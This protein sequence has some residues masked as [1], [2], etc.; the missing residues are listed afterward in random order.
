[1]INN[2]KYCYIVKMRQNLSSFIVDFRQNSTCLTSYYSIILLFL[3]GYLVIF[4]NFVQAQS[5]A[6]PPARPAA[7][8]NG[9]PSSAQTNQNAQSFQNTTPSSR[10][11]KKPRELTP[12]EQERLDSFARMAEGGENGANEPASFQAPTTSGYHGNVSHPRPIVIVKQLI[13]KNNLNLLETPHLLLITDLPLDD[14]LK[15]WPDYTTQIIDQLCDYFKIDKAKAASWQVTAFLMKNNVPFMMSDLLPDFI[16]QFDYGFSYN[17]YVWMYYQ[18][19]RDYQ[20]HLFLHECTHS[21]MNN[22]IGGC[23]PVWYGEGLAEYFGTHRIVN[24]KLQTGIVPVSRNEFPNWGRIKFI[25]NDLQDGVFVPLFGMLTSDLKSQDAR[26]YSWAWAM[27]WMMSAKPE[28]KDNILKMAAQMA[29]INKQVF[30]YRDRSDLFNENYRILYDDAQWLNYCSLWSAFISELDY[31]CTPDSLKITDR[32]TQPLTKAAALKIQTN[33]GWQNSGIQLEQGKS[34]RIKASG[35]YIIR[36]ASATPKTGQ[37]SGTARD[38]TAEPNGITI[39]YFHQA[40][41]GVLLGA[42]VVPDE[43]FNEKPAGFNNP[44]QIGY[45]KVW[46]IEET[47]A[48]WLKINESSANWADN[49]G[50][51][52][53]EIEE[54]KPSADAK[55]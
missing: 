28:Y 52:N 9:A 24:G 37:S 22:F 23:G 12:E 11:K 17:S 39:R 49:S 26:S 4:S 47:G 29:Q 43:G 36:K 35:Q 18:D 54:V 1:M 15:R 20:R 45:E 14:D 6:A 2:R 42:I 30:T 34:Y 19:S 55:K 38:W 5:V 13:A 32:P 53:V 7:A 33:V 41:L 16:P 25:Q 46:T 50:E 48:L 10:S 8:S 51:I 40:P 31:G 27:I 21:F 44:V 3:T